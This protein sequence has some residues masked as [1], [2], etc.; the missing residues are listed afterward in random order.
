MVTMVVQNRQG[1]SLRAR[2]AFAGCRLWIWTV[3]VVIRASPV[4]VE[5][6]YDSK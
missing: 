4:G 2:G 6:T 5:G 3:M 1:A